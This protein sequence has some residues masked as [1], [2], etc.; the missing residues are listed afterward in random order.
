MTEMYEFIDAEKDAVTEAGEKKFTVSHMCS[1][2]RV[3]TSGFY[4][5]RA[6][7]E[8]ATAR[9]RAHLAVLI[10]KIFTD[11][12]ET[13]GHRRIQAQLVRQGEC[14]TPELVRPDHR[15]AP[16]RTGAVRAAHRRAVRNLAPRP[17]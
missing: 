9:R 8:S 5:W 7:G 3:S 15:P 2:L 11:S 16:V 6:R 1:W 10:R 17:H 4:D 13:Y 12:D 14:A